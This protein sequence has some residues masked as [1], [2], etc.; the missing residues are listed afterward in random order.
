[1]AAAL[2]CICCR[3]NHNHQIDRL[4]GRDFTLL[5]S[6][7]YAYIELDTEFFA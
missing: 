6:G 3:G 4:S 5:A 7:A 1:M 2:I